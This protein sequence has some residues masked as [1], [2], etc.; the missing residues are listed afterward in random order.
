MEINNENIEQENIENVKS[1]FA[2]ETSNGAD[3]TFQL[4]TKRTL[5]I[6]AILFFT[7]LFYIYNSLHA[8]KAI[9]KKEELKTS[10]KELH[11][12]RISLE[13]EITN[14]SKQTEIAEKL[15]STGL[16]ELT[17]P[18]IKLTRDATQ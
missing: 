16:K 13:S 10:L 2:E 12:E 11:S 4:T 18:P 7:M 9:K 1:P 6:I 8:T 15:K 3:L 17:S 14:S 5:K